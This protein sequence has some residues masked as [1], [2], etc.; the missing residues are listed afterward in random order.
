MYLQTAMGQCAVFLCSCVPVFLCPVFLCSQVPV[1]S[2]FVPLSLNECVG[3]KIWSQRRTDERTDGRTD[4]R[5]YERMKIEKPGVGRPLLGPAKINY[6]SFLLQPNKQPA[7]LPTK[8]NILFNA[9]SKQ[10]KQIQNHGDEIISFSPLYF[11]MTKASHSSK[12]IAPSP[13]SSIF[14]KSSA[15]FSSPSSHQP[16][17]C[18][19]GT[20]AACC[21]VE[22][23]VWSVECGVWSVECGVWS[24]QC[25]VYSVQCARQ[26]THVFYISALILLTDLV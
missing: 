20:A 15:L 21:S 1:L 6:I 3:T 17:P 10:R 7:Y 23:G 14:L 24:V 26:D 19:L 16:S 13:L 18:C 25:T 5:T 11:S 22:C 4:E 8:K 12:E 2:L 9:F